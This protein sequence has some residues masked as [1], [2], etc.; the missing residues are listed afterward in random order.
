MNTFDHK[1]AEGLQSPQRRGVGLAAQGNAFDTP[2]AILLNANRMGMSDDNPVV[3][4]K[5]PQ[6]D[7]DRVVV[8]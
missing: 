1:V 5:P 6:Y 4:I 2:K 8:P 3:G 7:P